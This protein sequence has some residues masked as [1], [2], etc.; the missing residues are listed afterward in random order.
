MGD[1][2]SIMA[3]SPDSVGSAPEPAL[4]VARG[5]EAIGRAAAW[6]KR[7]H[8]LGFLALDAVGPDAPVEGPAWAACVRGDLA[9]I[10][11]AHH[12]LF[13][14]T[15]LARRDA[16]VVVDVGDADAAISLTELCA[17]PGV[18]PLPVDIDAVDGPEPSVVR[19]SEVEAEVLANRHDAS[20]LRWAA[21]RSTE[22]GWV[23]RAP[24]LLDLRARRLAESGI[25]PDDPAWGEGAWVWCRQSDSARAAALLEDLVVRADRHG[26]PSAPKLRLALGICRMLY[27][28]LALTAGLLERAAR[29]L[30]ALGAHDDEVLARLGLV[31]VRDRQG[32]DSRS[33]LKETAELVGP[34]TAPWARVRVYDSL[35]A[36][37]HRAGRIDAALACFR[38]A[39][40]LAAQARIDRLALVFEARAM[41]VAITSGRHEPDLDAL[42]SL[43]RAAASRGSLRT[44]STVLL[45]YGDIARRLG[46]LD[47]AHEAYETLRRINPSAPSGI[48]FAQLALERGA[49]DEASRLLREAASTREPTGRRV[50]PL[51]DA[52]ALPMHEARGDL[53]R[54][55]AALNAW[56]I[57][58][59]GGQV[60]VARAAEAAARLAREK[61]DDAALGRAARAA[62]QAMLHWRALGREDRVRDVIAAAVGGH[63]RGAPIP[64]GPLDLIQPVARGASC[65]VWRARHRELGVEV[66]VKVLTPA[67]GD[68]EAAA[69]LDAEVRATAR[70][71]H[72]HVVGVCDLG[73]VD[74]L[75]HA[76]AG[77]GLPAG[78]PWVAL[79]WVGGGSLAS[80]RGAL[81]WQACL[82]VLDQLLDALGH[83]H[84]SGLAHRDIKPGNLMW[85]GEDQGRPIVK[86]VDFG[87]AGVGHDTIAGTP[88]YMAPEQ[89]RAEGVG[90]WSDLYAVGCLAVALVQG[91]PPFE[92]GTLL[93]LRAAHVR[94]P[95]PE[96][97][98]LV[99]VPEGLAGWLE[100]LLAKEASARFPSAGAARAALRGLGPPV[101]RTL[102]P[103]VDAPAENNETILLERLDGGPIEAPPTRPRPRLPLAPVQ[104]WSAR[105]EPPMPRPL[106]RALVGMGTPA[107]VG[108]AEQQ[109][110]LWQALQDAGEGRAVAVIVSGAPGSGASLLLAWLLR[111]VRAAG[112]AQVVDGRPV[113]RSVSAIARA[114]LHGELVVVVADEPDPEDERMLRD[115]LATGGALLVVVGARRRALRSR[116]LELGARLCE[117]G[118]LALHQLVVMARDLAPLRGDVALNLARAADGSPGLLTELTLARLASDEL[119]SSP[120]GLIARPGVN[121]GV[122]SPTSAAALLDGLD[123][124]GRRALQVVAVLG[125][126]AT[127]DRCQRAWAELALAAHGVSGRL[128]L[129]AGRVRSRQP[130]D[131]AAALSGSVPVE[132]LQV[133]ARQ[134]EDSHE[135]RARAR[136][137]S[138]YVQIGRV[139]DAVDLLWSLVSAY[140]TELGERELV[141]L[142]RACAEALAAT[143]VPARDP[144]WGRLALVEART[145]LIGQRPDDLEDALARAEALDLP[146]ARAH[147][148]LIRALQRRHTDAA[149]AVTLLDEALATPEIRDDA[150]LRVAYGV[151]RAGIAADRV[152]LAALAE[153]AERLGLDRIAGDAN[154]GLARLSGPEAAIE[155]VSTWLTRAVDASARAG[156]AR[157]VATALDAR[158]DLA[159]RQG[160]LDGF[161]ADTERAATA[162][163]TGPMAALAW[164]DLAV[165]RL[166]AGRDQDAADLLAAA[167]AL[168]L[169]RAPGA[170]R[171]AGLLAVALAADGPGRPWLTAVALA[172]SDPTPRPGPV[173][174][175]LIDLARSRAGRAGHT[176][177][178]GWLEA[179]GRG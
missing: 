154:L 159:L 10:E 136:L 130:G 1:N 39:A 41:E 8:Q 162:V 80:R 11:L 144:R 141:E 121:L 137:V 165:A 118:R 149:G 98:P 51:L 107:L 62:R 147:A 48:G 58:S 21:E 55:E 139:G 169:D 151:A 108:R 29:E 83:A 31:I 135:P 70:L 34:R 124:A 3:Q 123:D 114:R 116:W 72:P 93:E 35:G 68:P 92:G 14:R 104:P 156:S 59:H 100:G 113:L 179:Q 76:L 85:A 25:G 140:P 168:G 9:G 145:A 173:P 91:R 79:E 117:V 2:Q 146:D 66:A 115:E 122:L 74:E 61:A 78:S 53:A 153:E 87:L 95:V 22:E 166:V 99:D 42:R 50:T 163:N 45:L 5:P 86:L 119:V 30:A 75:A 17:A 148:P 71:R 19:L 150:R 127:P 132:V 47:E 105:P 155:T 125:D 24:T 64:L 157:G 134:L 174:R 63:R 15:V 128:E 20:V 96:L 109:A 88:A 54:W 172:G 133:C 43:R 171:Q 129:H 103:E 82:D 44:A 65:L 161:L 97:H 28:E 152:K 6:T 112:C 81:P 126:H 131:A 69:A 175:L 89:F 177:R 110:L 178:V 26:W 23:L 16:L 40:A 90:P 102:R 32:L 60:D 142:V 158:A 52:L 120:G 12:W 111:E 38:Q 106:G 7:L 27:G 46:A 73:E 94:A 77:R 143:G 160:D 33:M 36:F 101:W 67:E 18:K 56:P 170:R 49:F 138:L 13:S 164:L 57:H 176:E 37:H 167:L 4:W 84:A